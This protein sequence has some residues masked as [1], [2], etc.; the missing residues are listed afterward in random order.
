MI[1]MQQNWHTVLF[2]D[3]AARK[4]GVWYRHVYENKEYVL[5][6]ASAHLRKGHVVYA[7]QHNGKTIMDEEDVRALCALRDDSHPAR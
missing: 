7:I 3:E 4:T 6:A 1:E 2:G 5:V